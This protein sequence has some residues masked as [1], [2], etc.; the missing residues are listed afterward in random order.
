MNEGLTGVEI[1][2]ELQLPHRLQKT[3]HAQGF[4]GSVSHNVKAIYQRYMTWFDGNPSHLWEH[5]PVEA[6][7]RYISCV[8]GVDEVVEKAKGFCEA[9][10]LRFAATLLN[11]AVFA[12]PESQ[13]AKALLAS[14]YER[15]GYGCEN[16]PWRNFYISGAMELQGVR[17]AKTFCLVR[18]EW[19]RHCRFINF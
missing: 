19:P 17:A 2:E 13:N 9:G 4:Y 15:L 3:W 18:P 10:D 11:H 16:G 1:A 14:T 8:G 7:K 5:P 6:A 12:V